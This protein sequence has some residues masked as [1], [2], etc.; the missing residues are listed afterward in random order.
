MLP[1]SKRPTRRPLAALV[2]GVAVLVSACSKKPETAPVPE[3]SPAA[4]ATA[5]TAPATTATTPATPIAPVVDTAAERARREAARLKAR[6]DSIAAA[7]ML[8]SKTAAELKAALV[9]TVYFDYDRAELRDDTRAA[10]E[11]KLP[12]LRANSALRL[13]VQGHTDERGS[14]EYNLA[15]GQR[16]AAS[17]Q[18]FFTDRG[19]EAGR[20]ALVSFGR[21]KPAS[22]GDD[23]ASRSKNRR[24]EFEILA[25]GEGLAGPR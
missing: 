20:F 17:V 8:A 25:G 21:E 22:A 19:V 4:A 23:D 2:L 12:I 5:S 13:R 1:T 24:A 11:A 6:E 16:R 15:L 9:A 18:R 10:L 7:R 14:D 3:T